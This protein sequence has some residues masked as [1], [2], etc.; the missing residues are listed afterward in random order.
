MKWLVWHRFFAVVRKEFVQMRRDKLTFG[1]M[2]GVPLMQLTMFGFAINADPRELPTV[3][4]SADESA[5]VRTL[6]A[7]IQNSRYF[8]LE[9]GIH[10]RAEA[11]AALQRGDVQ[12]LIEIPPQFTRSLLRGEH[13]ALLVTADATDPSA[14]GNAIAT[15]NLL[16][17]SVFQQEL[18]GPLAD[19]AAAAAPFEIRLHKR[20][21]PEGITQYNIVPG[22]M[23][24]VLTMTMIM[25][26]A[27]AITKEHE[28]GT[29]ESLLAMPLQALEV[30]LGKIVPY[31]AVGYVQV[32]VILAAAR[33]IFHV[34]II[35]SVT[36]LLACALLFILANLAVG[37][38]ISST[39]RS[40]TQAMQSSFFFMLPSILMTGFMFPFR[41]MP[42]WAQWIGEVLPLTH[43]LRIVRGILLKG[44]GWQSI[45]GEMA[46]LALFT[47]LMMALGVKR[48]RRTLD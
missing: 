33:F 22:L 27:L 5:Y 7:A 14:T 30:M 13:P 34:P 4:I 40:Q 36:L 39:V 28:R 47:V 29:M 6:S 25:M 38:T 2:I 46:A 1:M 10:T 9:S 12:F 17:N 31:I 20:Y 3:I 32:L 37:I 26:T 43:F 15:F 19:L 23:G 44:N 21:N 24:V 8:K 45:A 11:D 41:G 16:A 42:H 35:G 18:Q 48:Y